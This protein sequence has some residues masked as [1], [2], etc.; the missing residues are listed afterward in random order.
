MVFSLKFSSLKRCYNQGRFA[1]GCS[2]VMGCLALV[3]C[4]NNSP[5]YYTLMHQKGPS[6]PASL[7][8]VQTVKVLLPSVPEQLDR[9]TMV[10]SGQSYRMVMDDGATWSEPLSTLIG[11]TLSA[12]L[13]QRLPGRIVFSQNDAVAASPQAYVSLSITRF[14]LGEGRHAVIDGI[15]SI[16]PG[17]EATGTAQ[18]FPVHWVSPQSVSQ[19]PQALAEAL[20]EGVGSVADQ[21]A[22]VLS[23]MHVPA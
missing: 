15:L 23:G 11:H 12:N 14:D 4:S 10:L 9:D 13:G 17:G 5:T 7:G 3:G 8:A 18:S 6:Y 22:Q 1:L 19:R 21:A 2:V 16:K 20:S